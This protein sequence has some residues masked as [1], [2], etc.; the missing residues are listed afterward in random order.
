MRIRFTFGGLRVEA[1]LVG[2]RTITSFQLVCDG[3]RRIGIGILLVLELI[4]AFW[5]GQEPFRW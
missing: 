1:A 3:P 4:G 2:G 5:I